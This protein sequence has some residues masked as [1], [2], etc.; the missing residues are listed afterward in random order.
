MPDEHNGMDLESLLDGDELEQLRIEA[1]RRGV[2]PEQ[3]IIHQS[4]WK[5]KGS[6]IGQV[7]SHHLDGNRWLK[8]TPGHEEVLVIPD[9]NSQDGTQNVPPPEIDPNQKIFKV[10]SPNGLNVRD[11]PIGQL[12][13]QVIGYLP[14]GA[15]VTALE[16]VTIGQDVWAR[17]GDWKCCAVKY[18]GVV[19]L[20]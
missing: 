4:A 6:L 17:I 14:C 1:G 11:V 13:S 9:G 20:E 5:W 15:T 8:G 3:V 16:L 19:Y 18:K 7:G 2:S 10:I 12:G